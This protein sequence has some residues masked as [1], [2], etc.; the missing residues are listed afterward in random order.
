MEKP[1]AEKQ[2]VTA[3]ASH[4][5]GSAWR[6]IFN[7]VG[8][9]ILSQIIAAFTVGIIAAVINPGEPTTTIFDN[10]ISAQFFY[11]LIAEGTAAGAVLWLVKRQKMNFGAIG[12]GRKPLLRDLGWAAGGMVAFYILAIL[13]SYL[14]SLFIS[15]GE[16]DKSQD[17]GF[18]NLT[19]AIDHILAFLS[20][21]I[22]PPLGE[23]ILVR[24]YLY[25]GLRKAWRFVPAMLVTSFLF[26]LAHLDGGIG[27][28]VV[29]AAA[30]DTFML[31]LVLV[32]VREHTGAL[33]AGMLIHAA[34]NLIAYSV[35]FK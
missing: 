2:A 20:L 15:Q 18:N 25:S 16:L 10:S 17:I 31:S 5:F 1:K 35:H 28:S 23:E 7:A 29:W 9:F 6:V 12:L 34:N 22:I 26:G 3:E 30:A 4:G 27:G 11:V 13:T 32:Y 19:T 21:V 24:G 14:L 8:I 33:Y